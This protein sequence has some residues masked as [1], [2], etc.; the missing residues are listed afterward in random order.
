MDLLLLMGVGMMR[1]N[2]V[3]L[4][5]PENWIETP[6]DNSECDF[7]E[8]TNVIFSVFNLKYS[9]AILRNI[10]QFN[11]VDKNGT[12][13]IW[14]STE[15][16]GLTILL[17]YL[18]SIQHEWQRSRLRLIVLAIAAHGETYASKYNEM[19]D[20]LYKERINAEVI[21]I[22]VV[23]D[24]HILPLTLHSWKELMTRMSRTDRAQNI[25]KK[26]FRI[27]LLSDYIRQYS[28]D[29]SFIAFAM[30][31]PEH[32]SEPEIFMA[33]LEML[34]RIQKPFL[35]VIGNGEQ[36]LNWTT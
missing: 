11:I 8:F 15:D 28:S 35:F 6:D 1:P 31:L 5:Y 3:F 21:V 13:D 29:S 20:L 34:S 26:T 33:Y 30:P 32:H 4:E 23:S 12:I 19:A 16:G 9:L 27:L 14:W 2:T 25:D 24:I 22:E 10:D 17:P 36:V 18:L 7:K